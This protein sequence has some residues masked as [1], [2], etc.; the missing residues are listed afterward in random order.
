[1]LLQPLDA[2]VTIATLPVNFFISTSFPRR[3]SYIQYRAD[4]RQSY[5]GLFDRRVFRAS[6][7]RCGITLRAK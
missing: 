6:E 1:M 5:P 3:N 2:P 7:G 4:E